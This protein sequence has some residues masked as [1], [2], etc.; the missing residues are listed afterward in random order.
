MKPTLYDRFMAERHVEF[1][2]VGMTVTDSAKLAQRFCVD[3]D[4]VRMA[5]QVR[6]AHM[7]DILDLAR[8]PYPIVWVEYDPRAK[9]GVK[10]YPDTVD[11]CGHL[12]LSGTRDKDGKIDEDE[13][14]TFIVTVESKGRKVYVAPYVVTWEVEGREGKVNLLVGPKRVVETAPHDEALGF[15]Q[16]MVCGNHPNPPLPPWIERI[17]GDIA[18]P[19][20]PG[21]RTREWATRMHDLFVAHGATQ[22]LLMGI[23][24]LMAHVPTKR[25][26]MQPTGRW[27]GLHGQTHP[28][29]SVT[30]V[31]IEVGERLVYQR[32]KNAVHEIIQHRRRHDV[33]G[34][35]RTIRRG[36]PE[37]YKVFVK[38]HERG[39]ES[40]GRITHDHYETV[41]IVRHKGTPFPESPV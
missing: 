32:I 29:N 36:T 2:H 25:T 5:A 34:H 17:G 21:H 38:A 1:N 18:L 37:E 3:N 26:V 14:V 8:L 13:S 24:A 6:N 31:R 33:R 39:D 23:I 30:T 20:V 7:E 40:L 27:I 9:P 10:E 35:W 12:I 41:R 28:H 19:R 4:T 11:R 22:S 15:K 16:M